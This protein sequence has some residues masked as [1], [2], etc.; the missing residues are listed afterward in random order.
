MESSSAR[1]QPRVHLVLD[2]RTPP[3]GEISLASELAADP[4][5]VGTS[6]ENGSSGS[7]RYWLRRLRLL[8]QWL[9]ELHREGAG[10]ADS[11][12]SGASSPELD[13]LAQ[14]LV[15][16][17]KQSVPQVLPTP[18]RTSLLEWTTVLSQPRGPVHGAFDLRRI[19]WLPVGGDLVVRAP[20]GFFRAHPAVDVGWLTGDLLE[21]V[22]RSRASGGDPAPYEHLL[23]AFQTGYRGIDGG[24]PGQLDLSIY[25]AAALRVTARALEAAHADELTTHLAQHLVEHCWRPAPRKQGPPS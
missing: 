1:I 11:R 12:Q 10:T 25:R 8:G 2:T 16:D 24:G 5:A 18:H 4:T 14:R 17:S 13:V 7:E 22:H 21:L 19:S 6:D 3:A 9:R 15:E 20:G 23:A